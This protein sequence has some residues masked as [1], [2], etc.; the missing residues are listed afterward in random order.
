MNE[1]C[2]SPEDSLHQIT[3]HHF[4][5][6]TGAVSRSRMVHAVRAVQP[7]VVAF[8]WP[9]IVLRVTFLA[10]FSCAQGDRERGIYRWDVPV[11][12]GSRSHF[13]CFRRRLSRTVLSSNMTLSVSSKLCDLMLLAF[14]YN[15]V[16]L[17]SPA[18]KGRGI[19]F[20]L[21]FFYSPL[22]SSL[23][24]L[25]FFLATRQFVRFRNV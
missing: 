14:V 19:C 16:L 2:A 1:K 17:V 9:P 18:C 3:P 13:N 6:L 21:L 25:I 7:L 24:N 22:L 4:H 5:A 20:A 12:N 8:E 10:Y 23:I 15:S 11:G